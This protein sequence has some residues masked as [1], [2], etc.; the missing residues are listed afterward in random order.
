MCFETRRQPCQSPTCGKLSQLL[1]IGRVTPAAGVPL[2]T[3]R[4]GRRPWRVLW[5]KCG[6]GRYVPKPET[7]AWCR[8]RYPDARARRGPI[9][10]K[11]RSMTRVDELTC[12]QRPAISCRSTW[13]RIEAVECD[14]K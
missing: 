8:S 1:M 13:G 6:N 4:R 3:R 5:A 11:L 14:L 9:V 2:V 10:A 12:K 7:N